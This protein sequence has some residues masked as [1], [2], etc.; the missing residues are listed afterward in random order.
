MIW[1]SFPLLP[2]LHTPSAPVSLYQVWWDLFACPS[3]LHLKC[4]FVP[5]GSR[6]LF[7]EPRNKGCSRTIARELDNMQTSLHLHIFHIGRSCISRPTN[8]FSSRV[9]EG[10]VQ[11]H[12]WVCN[13]LYFV[14]SQVR[15]YSDCPMNDIPLQPGAHSW[16]EVRT[17]KAFKSWKGHVEVLT[18][19][20]A[21]HLRLRM[22]N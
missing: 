19:F 16:L 17:R 15:T 7:S 21:T 8:I 1:A 11:S 13:R 3:T 14:C 6:I 22:V 20:F 12:V 18:T 5:L 4:F 10:P 9:A 2:T